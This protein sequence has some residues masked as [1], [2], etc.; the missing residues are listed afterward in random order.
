MRAL[1]RTPLENLREA[2]AELREKNEIVKDLE[3]K[4]VVLEIKNVA[5]VDRLDF[6]EDTLTEVILTIYK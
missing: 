6:L 4:N 3:Q 1:V 5:L 2:E